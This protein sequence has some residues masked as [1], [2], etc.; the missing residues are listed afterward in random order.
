M[1]KKDP[2]D[3]LPEDFSEVDSLYDLFGVRPDATAEEIETAYKTKIKNHHPDRSDRDD[4]EQITFALNRGV[5]VIGE[6]KERMLYDKLGHE[7]YFNSAVGAARPKQETTGKTA[8]D[9]SLYDMIQMTNFSAHKNT[10]PWW[11]S[12]LKTTG[13]KVFVWSALLLAA[14]FGGLVFL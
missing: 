9:P 7:E 6:Q 14:L 8:E 5:K 2:L 11:K 10:E 1:P 13:F 12:A 4:A 3:R